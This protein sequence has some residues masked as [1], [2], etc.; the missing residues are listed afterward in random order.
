MRRISCM[1]CILVVLFPCLALAAGTGVYVTPKVSLSVQHTKGTAD[2]PAATW[3][4][5]HV[6]GASVG[7]AVALGYDFQPSLDVPVR[8]EL[9][10]G[11]SDH[12][13][14]TGSTRIYK[15]R[16]P[17]QAKVSVQTLLFNTYFDILNKNGFIPYIGAGAG[18]AFITT[19]GH[20]LGMSA[21]RTEAVPAAQV[22]LGCAYAFTEHIAV[23]L[24]YRF[25]VMGGTETSCDAITLRLRQNSMHQVTLGLR[26]TF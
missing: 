5:K 12:I 22:G 11:A 18:A 3:G 16:F 26:M 9:E 14:K 25:V 23:D 7:G 17:F 8:L 20:C 4:P 21:R 13:T 6:V 24:G 15:K 1:A 19:R 10:Y 2:L